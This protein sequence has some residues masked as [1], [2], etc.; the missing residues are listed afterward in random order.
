MKQDKSDNIEEQL[1]ALWRDPVSPPDH[2]TEKLFRQ[3]TQTTSSRSWI[4]PLWYWLGV[5]SWRPLTVA[6]LPLVAGIAIGAFWGGESTVL[7]P[8]TLLLAENL[9]TLV[10]GSDALFMLEG[11]ELNTERDR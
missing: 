2:L 4:E 8:Q 3:V 1:K 6:A 11:I 5:A 7:E 10:G 9:D